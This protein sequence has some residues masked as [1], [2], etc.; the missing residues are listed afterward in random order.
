MA[1]VTKPILLDATGRAMNEQLTRIADA[2]GAQAGTTWKGVKRIV[3]EN[4][5]ATYFPVGSQF[6][7]Y[8]D[9]YGRMLY[10]VVAHDHFKPRGAGADFHTMT[11]MAHDLLSDKVQFGACALYKAESGLSAGTYHFTIDTTVNRWDA[12][13]YQFTLTQA[14]PAGGVVCI[15]GA[16]TSVLTTLKAQTFRANGNSQ[17]AAAN[18]NFIEQVSITQGSGGTALTTLCN[19]ERVGRGW[20]NYGEST[21]RIWLNSAAGA[22]EW[23]E[24]ITPYSMVNNVSYNLAGF[25]NGLDAELAEVLTACEYT[26]ITNNVYEYGDDTVPPMHAYTVVDKV[27]V[28]TA[29]ELGINYGGSTDTTTVL[30]YFDGAENADRV[31][32]LDGTAEI[33]ITRSPEYS[34]VR[35]ISSITTTGTRTTSN[36]NGSY[37]IAPMFTI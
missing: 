23:F 1:V 4:K 15:S 17:P 18:T 32:R 27:T 6:L 25:L 31:K 14:I 33:Y 26:T 24:A 9:A 30:A 8:H 16:D 13:T 21:A 5:G 19:M 20:A 22:G 12:G 34:G 2:L 37:G 3:R 36:A 7:V 11:L 28:A 10:D 35:S 29:K